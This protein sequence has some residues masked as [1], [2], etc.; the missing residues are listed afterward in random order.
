MSQHP[1]AEPPPS[2]AERARGR[3]RFRATL[4]RVLLVQ[5][6]TL[7]GLWLLQSRYTG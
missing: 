6:V 5:V 2:P 4:A 7:L 3:A 1:A